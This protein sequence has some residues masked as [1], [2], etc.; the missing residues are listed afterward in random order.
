MGGSEPP[1]LR[2]HWAV[3]KG[4]RRTKGHMER[5]P[6]A[7]TSPIWPAGGSFGQ[8]TALSPIGRG[9]LVR[10]KERG[11]GQDSRPAGGRTRWVGGCERIAEQGLDEQPRK[12]LTGLTH[13]ALLVSRSTGQGAR[14]EIGHAA[15]RSV[16]R[17]F[18]RKA[19]AW[20][21]GFGQMLARTGLDP[22]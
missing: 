22:A 15:E 18:R 6:Y 10:P 16:N 7:L 11:V 12:Y 4:P 13:P 8:T 2:G 20:Q 3:P 5:Q 17:D 21:D 14:R 1:W 9:T 19:T